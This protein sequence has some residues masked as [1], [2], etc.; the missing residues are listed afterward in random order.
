V[1]HLLLGLLVFPT[2]ASASSILYNNDFP[3]NLMASASTPSGNGFIEHE[4]ADDFLLTSANLI[5]SA[6]FTGL[7]PAG[8]TIQQLVVEIYRV[9]PNDSDVGRTSGPP[10]FSTPQVPTRMN[11]PSDVE[12]VGRDSAAGEL[13]FSTMVLVPSFTALNSVVNGINPKPNQ[14]TLGEGPKTGQE[15]QFSVTFTSPFLLPADHYFFV[16]Q[17]LLGNS[18]VPFLWLSGPRPPTVTPFA[19]D[20]QSWIRDANLDPDWLRI[21][22]DIVDGTTP[23]TFNA[24]FSISGEPAAAVPEPASL[25]LLGTGLIG[26]GVRRYRRRRQ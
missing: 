3:L 1:T 25:V 16:P 8:A 13:T 12:F 4:S 10:T 2:I 23:P 14:A 11:S 18:T 21:G 24:A 6:T 19:P 5:T 22:T 17:V 20:L 7:V 9:F 15:I 26:A